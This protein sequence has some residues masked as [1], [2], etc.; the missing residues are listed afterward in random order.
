MV[1]EHCLHKQNARRPNPF[2]TCGLNRIYKPLQVNSSKRTARKF[3][4]MIWAFFIL[5][6]CAQLD[7]AFDFV[8]FICKSLGHLKVGKHN[9]FYEMRRQKPY[10]YTF[11]KEGVGLHFKD[12]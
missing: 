12:I 7:L 11:T 10:T 3:D 2:E 8:L 4:V 6:Y 1:P 5:W 9:R